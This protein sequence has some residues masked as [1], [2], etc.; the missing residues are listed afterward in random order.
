MEFVENSHTYMWVL[1]WKQVRLKA[2]ASAINLLIVQVVMQF[3]DFF[4]K[5]KK[6]GCSCFR[7][8]FSLGELLSRNYLV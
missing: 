1:N 4:I 3:S 6:G 2:I 5:T 8:Y 7:E